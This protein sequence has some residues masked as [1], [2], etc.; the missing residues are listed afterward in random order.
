MNNTVILLLTGGESKRFHSD[1]LVAELNSKRLI[2]HVI[3]TII[4]SN[5]ASK[6]YEVGRNYS[7]FHQIPKTIVNDPLTAIGI[8]WSYL[9]SIST[10]TPK[11]ALVLAGDTFNLTTEIVDFLYWFPGDFNV[12]PDDGHLQPLCA[13][14]SSMSLESA[15]KNHLARRNQRVRSA[16]IGPTLTLYDTRWSLGQKGSPFEDIDTVEDLERL[17]GSSDK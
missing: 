5:L 12:V 2:D 6:C 13:R 7:D 16:L 4:Q 17:R 10:I 1:K 15:A 11:N 9:K 14:W 3:G 8:A